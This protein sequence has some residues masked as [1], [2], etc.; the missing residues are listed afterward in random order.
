MTLFSA[1]QAMLISFGLFGLVS[2]FIGVL[3]FCFNI[4]LRQPSGLILAGAFTVL[5]Y[6]SLFVGKLSF[7]NK[8]YY[9]SPINWSSMLYLDFGSAGSM[10]SPTYAVSILVVAILLMSIVSVAVFCRQDI[11]IQERRG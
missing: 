10:P 11:T 7:G 8:I 4:I 2:T 5:S 6:F 9:L 1:S 3:I